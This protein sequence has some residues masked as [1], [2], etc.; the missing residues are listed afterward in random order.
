MAAFAPPVERSGIVEGHVVQKGDPARGLVF[1]F[2]KK[3]LTFGSASS[4]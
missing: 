2:L 3:H 1:S 4:L